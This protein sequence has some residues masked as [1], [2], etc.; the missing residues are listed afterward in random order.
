MKPS[1]AGALALA[2]PAASESPVAA[3]ATEHQRYQQHQQHRHWHQH[4]SEYNQQQQLNE[5]NQQ[6]QQQQLSSSHSEDAD[7]SRSGTANSTAEIGTGSLGAGSVDD[8][9]GGAGAAK[10][11]RSRTSYSSKQIEILEGEFKISN[12]PEL[13]TRERLAQLTGLTESR[14]Q[15]SDRFLLHPFLSSPLLPPPLGCVVGSILINHLAP[16]RLQIW[17]SNRRARDRKSSSSSLN[18]NPDSQPATATTTTVAPPPPKLDPTAGL[19]HAPERTAATN[20]E[21]QQQHYQPT[22]VIGLYQHQHQQ[23][24]QQAHAQQSPPGY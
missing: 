15:V 4:L 3:A 16:S 13:A 18:A 19:Y 23:Q 5:Y 22:T 6:Q 10:Q 8:S 11:R 24:Q 17:F 1:L 9:A 7:S 21:Q 12:Y 2:P 14:V 20:Y